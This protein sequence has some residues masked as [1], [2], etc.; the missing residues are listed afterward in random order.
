MPVGASR[1]SIRI[2]KNTYSF[3]ASKLPAAAAGLAAL[4]CCGGLAQAQ[5][6][7]YRPGLIQANF[8]Y[9]W[10]QAHP[11]YMNWTPMCAASIFADPS[12]ERVFGTLMADTG[13]SA[14]IVNTLSG[15]SWSWQNWGCSGFGYAGEMRVESG[16]EYTFGQCF[17]GYS[18]IVVDG[19]TV[20]DNMD[21]WAWSSGV[22]TATNSGWVAFDVRVYDKYGYGN[23]G[24]YGGWNPGFGLAFNT[25]GVATSAPKEA[26]TMLWDP[27]DMSL[28][29]APATAPTPTAP[30]FNSDAPMAFAFD[31]AAFSVSAALIH[32]VADCYARAGFDGVYE[33]SELIAS[34]AAAPAVVSG[35]FEEL[36][37]DTIYTSAIFADDGNGA[38]DIIESDVV[39]YNGELWLE[40]TRDATEE[41]LADGIVT[42][43]RASAD[44]ATRLP[45][46]VN[47][48]VIEDTAAAGINYEPLSG[49]VT[50]EAGEASAEIRIKPIMDIGST[51]D[52]ALAIAL[53]PG[54]YFHSAAR[55]TNTVVKWTRTVN[56]WEAPLGAAGLASEGSNW[57][58]GR[59]PLATDHIV[60]G[61]YSVAE[62]IW[63]AGFAALPDAVASWTQ[64]SGYTNVVTFNIQYPD[65]PGAAF[66]NFT[67]AGNV[68]I[69]G[70]KW[71]HPANPTTAEQHRL[72]VTVGGDFTLAAGAAINLQYKG[73]GVGQAHPG[74]APG[75]HGGSRNNFAHVYGDIKEPVNLGSGGGGHAGGGALYLTAGGAATINGAINASSFQTDSVY[76]NSTSGG[77]G[78]SIYIK[79][80]AIN[81]AGAISANGTPVQATIAGAAGSSGGRVALI[82]TGAAE[83]GF[84][85]A[86]VCARGDLGDANQS[87]G[88]GT[89]FIQ[90]AA[91]THG[92]LLVDNHYVTDRDSQNL[93]YHHFPNAL[94]TTCLPLGETWTFDEIITRGRGILSI[95]PGATLELPG[96]FGSVRSA[97]AYASDQRH[98]SNGILYLG[99]DIILG[100]DAPYIFQSNWVF[101]AAVPYHFDGDV[102]VVN[103][104][105]LGAIA[106]LR[107][108]LD[109]S[110][111]SEYIIDGDLLVDATSRIT[112][113]RAGMDYGTSQSQK[114]AHGGQNGWFATGTYTWEGA[115]DPSSRVYGSILNPVHPG[116]QGLNHS[117]VS[118]T[119][120]GPGG[121]V[122]IL[123]ISGEFQLDGALD[124]S[125]QD[126]AG[127]ITGGS[128]GSVNISAGALSGSGAIDASGYRA[129]GWADQRLGGAPGR[130]AVRL[131]DSGADF[132]AFGE[133]NIKAFG[134]SSGDTRLMS[135]AGTIYLQTAEDG[136]GGGVVKIWNNNASAN[137]SF[138]PFPS[139][140]YGGET[141]DFKNARLDI[142]QAARVKLFAPA[143]VNEA[144]TRAGT[145]LDLNGQTL[146]LKKLALEDRRVTYSGAFTAAQLFALGYTG[147][148]D[149]SSNAD[150]LIEIIADSTLLILR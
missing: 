4:C 107:N 21:D 82:A 36:D 149:T 135:S 28:F 52:T 115:W 50:L 103:N 37:A 61:A 59:V 74:S 55:A 32:G 109:N 148:I 142:G 54:M 101:H 102:R 85:L 125:T 64:E 117:L 18:R 15:N 40:S 68:E 65:A 136:E 75:I 51:G 105:A 89:V 71:T 13:G 123:N 121:G 127:H 8:K 10:D 33:V 144:L 20:V 133:S 58:L 140:A 23:H 56:T 26:W 24:P 134:Y 129:S 130:I 124:V 95:P 44:A 19:E 45:L 3:I 99:G 1:W 16:V 17:R 72:R 114:G 145:T 27:G 80:A 73:H 76:G 35:A 122:V 111:K 137:P 34:G 49:A 106:G 70:G 48:T 100:G 97:T 78:G 128:A 119:P 66:T 2:M 147:V 120:R 9:G 67:V 146:T 39:F 47:Y 5:S 108:T 86:N 138:T 7:Y 92:T 6:T 87:A 12:A 43:N 29:R 98:R 93:L 14:P 132:S 131:T 42:V 112:A 150:G 62:M 38:T 31:G 143:R 139:T 22:Y 57:S 94:G 53:A 41:N 77:A 79:A 11:S 60:L 81:G 69:F 91:Q 118:N 96:G 104:G 88:A 25:N 83:L 110:N 90:T 30:V 116:T 126:A 84:T 141:D 63:D 113:V 46:V